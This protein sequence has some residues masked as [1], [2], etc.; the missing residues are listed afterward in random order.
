[1][2]SAAVDWGS[3]SFRA[4]RF[5][6][7]GDLVDS[8]SS[9][10]GIKFV[11]MQNYES[12]LRDEVGHWFSPGDTVLLSGMISSRSGWM[13]SDYIEC[14][15]RLHDIVSNS[16][17]LTLPDLDLVFLPGISQ[18]SPPDVMRG[19]ELQLLGAA[20]S[21]GE[22]VFVIP[23]THS[24]WALVDDEAVIRFRTIPTGEL[25][26]MMIR[27]SLMGALVEK[28][29]ES[30][31]SFRYGVESGFSS[32]NIVSDLFS[33]RS[34]VLLGQRSGNEAYAWLSGLIIGN[35][36]REGKSEFSQKDR[37]IITIGPESLCAR[38]LAAFDYLGIQA[39]SA[40]IQAAVLGFR[41]I[42]LS[43]H[44]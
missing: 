30:T 8:L 3:S 35:E 1:M 20:S 16:R 14:P 26:D 44:S 7:S 28:N 41:K 25:F 6:A 24:K 31:A 4:Y 27:H 11:P 43:N 17:H 13:E 22:K 9:E 18:S 33:A 21:D 19:E 34:S 29:D 23:G 39:E 32:R 38:Y 37:P 40:D 42:I 2:I 12:V 5:D 10:L 36:I 15:A